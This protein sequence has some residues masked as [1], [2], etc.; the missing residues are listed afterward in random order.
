MEENL[1]TLLNEIL[2][3]CFWDYSYTAQDIDNIIKS[4]TKDEKLYLLKKIILNYKEVFKAVKIFDKDE[5]QELLS[6]IPNGCFRY[7]F[8]NTRLMALRNHYLGEEYAP[9]RL[10]WSLR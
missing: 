2:Q 9:K 5:L 4:G 3:Q 7:E 6:E 1:N 10:R 8:Q